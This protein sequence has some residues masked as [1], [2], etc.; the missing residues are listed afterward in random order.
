MT[1]KIKSTIRYSILNIGLIIL[2]MVF[3]TITVYRHTS[4]EIAAFSLSVLIVII[5]AAKW[6]LGKIGIRIE[7]K[8]WIKKILVTLVLIVSTLFF[9]FL[10]FSPRYDKTASENGSQKKSEKASE[11]VETFSLPILSTPDGAEIFVDE[12]FFGRTNR[13]IELSRGTHVIMI[14]KSGYK[15]YLDKVVIPDQKIHSVVLEK[16]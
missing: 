4:N 1:D 15:E 9:G 10:A 6:M 7:I 12:E 8:S 5:S 16:Q 3:F 14:K 2:L 11:Y 13:S